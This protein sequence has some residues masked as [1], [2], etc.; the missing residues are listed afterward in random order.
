MA[1]RRVTGG[2]GRYLPERA[3]P[4]YAYVPG[5]QPHP[6]RDPNGHR[7]GV[8]EPSPGAV[9]P[10]RW[11]DCPAF[12]HG[13]DLFNHGYVWEAH[14]A[15][16]GVWRGCPPDSDAARLLRALIH[17]AAAGVKQREGRSRGVA[18]HLAKATAL[19]ETLPGSQR[20]F[21]LDVGELRNHAQNAA[22]IR[23][24]RPLVLRPGGPSPETADA[25]G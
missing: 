13:V 4:P 12:L 19:F 20:L 22:A 1:K 2:P 17:L 24:A 5:R 15:W 6:L 11:R 18:R 8:D 14:E 3:F 16:E 23:S 9:D 21:G 25:A 10:A 7:H